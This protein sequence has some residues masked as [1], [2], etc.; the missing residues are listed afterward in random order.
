[1]TGTPLAIAGGPP[2]AYVDEFGYVRFDDGWR[3]EWW[4]LGDD[5]WHVPAASPSVRQR[6]VD[7]TPVIETAM[8]VPGGDV[9]VRAAA[10]VTGD[11]TVVAFECENRASIPVALGLALVSP[12][13]AVDL[14][15]HPV[16][17]TSTWR[18]VLRAETSQ[19]VPDLATV[20]RGWLALARQGAQILT[21]DPN[22]DDALVAARC[23]LLLRQ[24]AL[25]AL[26][27]RAPRGARRRGR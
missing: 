2:L 16:T 19:P 25:A 6:R 23:D 4:V 18:G 9:V 27:K 1:M 26:G 20:A 14:A 15:V 21:N 11:G 24:G 3:V 17:H 13:E 10:T 5:H 8:R 7:N 12:T 22:T